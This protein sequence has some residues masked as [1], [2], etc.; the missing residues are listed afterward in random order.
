MVRIGALDQ[1]HAM[2]EFVADDTNIWPED[3]LEAH[4]ATP[5]LALPARA[6]RSSDTTFVSSTNITA[7]RPTSSQVGMVNAMSSTPAGSPSRSTTG[8]AP[9][10]CSYAS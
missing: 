6:L 4:S 1:E 2:L 7:G 9:R 5:E 3:I 10:S 8:R